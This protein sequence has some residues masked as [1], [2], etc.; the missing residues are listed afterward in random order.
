M[1]FW[2]ESGEINAKGTEGT[3]LGDKLVLYFDIGGSHMGE[4]LSKLIEL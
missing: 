3:L 1:V 4:S 2:S